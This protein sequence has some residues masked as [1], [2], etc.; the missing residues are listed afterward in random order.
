MHNLDA[1]RA[2]RL[3]LTQLIV[4]LLISALAGVLGISHL[5]DAFIG[6]LAA[7]AGN[8]VFAL[9][10]FGRYRAQQPGRIVAN[11]YGGEVIKILVV[12]AIFAAAMYGL[13]DIHPLTFFSAFLM[14]QVLPPLLAN[15][16]A[17]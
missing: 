7:L 8:A 2:K 3:L 13:P 17:S 1:R 12:V 16:V 14:V 4:L 5:R 9:W 10:V 6:G 11:L 15:R